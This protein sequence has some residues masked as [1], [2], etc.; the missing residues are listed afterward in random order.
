M[1]AELLKR[2][3]LAEIQP[4]LFP[5]SSFINRAMNDDAYVNNNTV[6]LPHSG[7]I[8]VATVDRSSLP[9]TIAKRTDAATNYTLEEITTDPTLIQ[10]SEEMIVAYNKRASVLDQ[11]VKEVNRKAEHRILTAWAGG[12]TTF[13]PST[14]A[15][16][17]PSLAGHTGSRKAFTVAD[18][19]SVKNRFHADDVTPDNSAVNG[20][21]LLTGQQL[22]D[23]LAIQAIYDASQYGSANLPSGVVARIMGFDIYVRSSTVVLAVGDTLKAEGAALAV[24]DQAAAV[25]WSPDYVRRAKGAVKVYIDEDKPEYYGS[26]FST[27]VRAGGVPSRNDNKGIYLLYET[28]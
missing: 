14:G 20:V 27:L 2:L 1:A 16:R 6:E 12:A 13:I 10:Y 9:A 11:H 22:S 7:T 21:G 19:L 28:D 17:T 18:I 24:T 26:I 15:T 5:S 4:K 25:F 3:F 8:P 23:L